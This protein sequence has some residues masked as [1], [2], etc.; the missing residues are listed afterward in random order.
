MR[1]SAILFSLYVAGALSSPIKR[2]IVYDDYVVM[3]TIIVTADNE[4]PTQQATQQATVHHHR[5]TT[6]VPPPP[7]PSVTPSITQVATVDPSVAPVISVTPSIT[8]VKSVTPP[9]PSS[10]TPLP[11]PPPS[12]PAPQSTSTQSDGSPLSDG[13]SLLTTINKWRKIYQLAELAWSSKLEKNAL[14][15]G[16]DGGGVNQNH[17]LNDGSMAQVITPGMV[18][19]YGDLKGDSCFELSY[20]AWLCEK[21]SDPQLKSDGTDQ[22]KLVSDDLHMYYSDTGHYDILTSKSYKNIGCAFAKNP[23]AGT[24]TPY[25]GLWVCDLA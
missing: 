20:V 7:P 14:K 4:Q 1:T 13:V 12:T 9:P 5:V 21:S 23:N 10:T 11:S 6:T 18:V 3:K 24:Q 25:Q 22:C 17:E 2:D 19:P 8:P 16:T 15:T